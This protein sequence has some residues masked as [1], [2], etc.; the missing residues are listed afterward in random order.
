M[1]MIVVACLVFLYGLVHLKVNF[2][3][4][5]AVTSLGFLM[6]VALVTLVLVYL[7]VLVMFWLKWTFLVTLNY[8]LLLCKNLLYL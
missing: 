3:L 6:N 7:Y 5:P 4:F 1:L 8:I 2:S